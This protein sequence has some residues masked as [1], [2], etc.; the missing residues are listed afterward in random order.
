MNPSET[1]MPSFW[2]WNAHKWRETF[3]IRVGGWKRKKKALAMKL[4]RVYG[5][6]GGPLSGLLPPTPQLIRHV[7]FLL[8]MH[9][10][11]QDSVVD[12]DWV[13]SLWRRLKKNKIMSVSP[14][15]PCTWFW[16]GVWD[17]I[18]PRIHWS[19]PGHKSQGADWVLP[20]LHWKSN[21]SLCS[22]NIFFSLIANGAP[23]HKAAAV[24]TVWTCLAHSHPLSAASAPK[25]EPGR[26]VSHK[27]ILYFKTNDYCQQ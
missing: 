9:I 14:W 24:A 5:D 25:K 6:W 20:L 1:S 17:T 26:A 27:Q 22:W 2:K 23:S 18:V 10:R 16:K 13:S 3:L 7:S 21:R 8:T 19:A 15:V 11:Q 4:C 12:F